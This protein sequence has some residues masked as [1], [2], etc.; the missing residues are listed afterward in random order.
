M[1]VF[2]FCSSLRSV[3]NK[4]PTLHTEEL[5]VKAEH[6]FVWQKG[7]EIDR[8]FLYI[9]KSSAVQPK[10]ARHIHNF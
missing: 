6:M 2:N 10:G 8:N 7:V 3:L 5:Q 9:R 1:Y 4:L